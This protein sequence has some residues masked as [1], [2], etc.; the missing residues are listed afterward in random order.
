MTHKQPEVHAPVGFKHIRCQKEVC[1]VTCDTQTAD[2]FDKVLSTNTES[3][4]WS[5]LALKLSQNM[6]FFYRLFTDFCMKQLDFAIFV[7]CNQHTSLCVTVKNPD[8][9]SNSNMSVNRSHATATFPTFSFFIYLVFIFNICCFALFCML[10][11]SI[12]AGLWT[13]Y[14]YDLHK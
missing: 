9:R 3:S 2:G 10:L 1:L 8:T 4:G 14:G 7:F 11:Y 6:I 12:Q 5:T 13:A